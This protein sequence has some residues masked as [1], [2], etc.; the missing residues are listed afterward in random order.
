MW[1]RASFTSSDP[2]VIGG[3]FVETVEHEGGFPRLI[4]T[5][6]GTENI[7]VRDIQLYLRRNG[8][9]DRAGPQ[10]FITGASTANQRIESWWGHLRKEGIEHW[11]QFFA[12]L[13]DEGHFS[14]DFLDKALIQFCFMSFIQ[15]DL[16]D[17]KHVWNS[18]RIRPSRNTSVPSGIPNVMH[19]AP[20]L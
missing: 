3:Y 14:G 16:N 17:I 19:H 4:R 1:L 18:H 8:Q 11:I 13:K 20:H 10:S 6:M 7:V 12:D 5:D 2:R 15:E 9:D